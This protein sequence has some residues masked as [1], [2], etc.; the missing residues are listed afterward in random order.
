[1]TSHAEHCRLEVSL[2]AGQ[3]DE[4]D[5]LRGF[6]ADFHPIQSAVIGLIDHLAHTIESQDIVADGTGPAS[7]HFMLVSEQPLTRMAS[8]VVQFAVR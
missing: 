4:C 7:L 5:D 6:L 8:A 2:V 3:I 1:M